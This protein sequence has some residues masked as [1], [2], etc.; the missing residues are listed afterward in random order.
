M[1]TF[2]HR[3]EKHV[4]TLPQPQPDDVEAAQKFPASG[5]FN[6]EHVVAEQAREPSLVKLPHTARFLAGLQNA[7]DRIGRDREM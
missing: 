3:L 1:T 5:Q 4:G 6:G 2:L 7:E